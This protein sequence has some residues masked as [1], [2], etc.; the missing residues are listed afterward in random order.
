MVQ[1][2]EDCLSHR[3]LHF[4]LAESVPW[5]SAHELASNTYTT[6]IWR[7]TDYRRVSSR[8]LLH[9][10]ISGCHYR[11]SKGP[12]MYTISL[13]PSRK[14]QITATSSDGHAFTITTPLLNGARYWLNL[15][16][17]PTATITTVWSSGSSHWSLRSTIGHAA[18]LTV[19][20]DRFKTADK[21][22]FLHRP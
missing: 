5:P 12:A 22:G 8:Q 4:A 16:A 15:G 9:K 3:E 20:N 13:E 10:R 19:V 18:K 2:P 7:L 21:G 6:T 11:Q 14:G 1:V 17:E